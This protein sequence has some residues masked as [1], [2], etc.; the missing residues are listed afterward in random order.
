LAIESPERFAIRLNGQPASTELAQGWWCDASLRRVALDTAA[1]RTGEN[2][3]ELECGYDEGFAG[4][5]AL[6]L[7]GDFGVQLRG[8]VPT[9]TRPPAELALGDWVVQGLP[10][11][12]GSGVYETNAVLRPV[13][14]GQRV[15]VRLPGYRG[16]AAKVWV[17]GQAAGITAWAPDEVDI[18]RLLPKQERSVRIGIE[19][20]GHRR[21]SHGPLHLSEKWPRW[22]GPGEFVTN[23]DRWTD[24]YQLVPVGLLEPPR[25]VVQTAGAR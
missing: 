19:V 12:A 11:Y 20:M 22:T 16:T 9:L 4:L 18:T 6:F 23:G 24:D 17:D 2:V 25:I 7:L 10:F 13:R 1:L 21:N 14:G 3:L 5:E 15:V 8:R